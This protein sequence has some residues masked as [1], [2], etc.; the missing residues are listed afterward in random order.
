[1]DI[2]EQITLLIQLQKLDTQIYNFNRRKEEIPLLIKDLEEELKRKG[3]GLK[4]K[5]NELKSLLVRQK[6][7][8]NELASKEET[9]KKC[10]VQ[11]Y[12]IKTNKEYSAMQ[13]EIEGHKAD[14][15]VLEDEI[16]AILDEADEKKKAIEKSKVA[17][18]EEEKKINEEEMKVNS[19]LKDIETQLNSLNAQRTGLAA[20][21]D[22]TM[23]GK[24]ERILKGKDGLAMVAV[25][26]DACGGCNL[27]LPPQVIN[28]I[29][30]KKDLVFCESCSRILYIEE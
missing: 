8:E 13:H 5:E 18:K 28:E 27:N 10:Q 14:K 26:E 3:E 7:R 12:Q 6:D 4:E 17:F 16:I 21:V 24:Y 23:L 1:M 9:I 22:K 29:N 15:S 2:A 25:R 30:M 20:K 11:L 19:E